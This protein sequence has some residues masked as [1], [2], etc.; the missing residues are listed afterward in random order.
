MAEVVA[1]Q[2]LVARHA[3]DHG[4]RSPREVLQEAVPRLVAGRVPGRRPAGT[5]PAGVGGSTPTGIA[6]P[7]IALVISR[8]ARREAAA[9]AA[10]ESRTDPR[11]EVIE[12]VLAS[13]QVAG[14][15]FVLALSAAGWLWLV[16]QRSVHAS[17]APAREP[18]TAGVVVDDLP[19]GV[20]TN[21]ALL[22]PLVVTSGTTLVLVMLVTCLLLAPVVNPFYAPPREHRLLHAST[23][24]LF[25]VLA[26]TTVAVIAS[27]AR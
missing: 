19:D 27:A 16:A 9:G 24:V 11:L 12:R 14:N 17:S 15:A 3:R 2:R 6:P 20:L 26:M 25:G 5:C 22:H 8:R 7:T 10:A 18:G 4:G 23:T 13:L 21:S 1:S